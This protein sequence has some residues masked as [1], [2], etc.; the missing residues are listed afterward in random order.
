MINNDILSIVSGVK[1]IHCIKHIIF[2]CISKFL[3]DI[4]IY[5]SSKSLWRIWEEMQYKNQ[6]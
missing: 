3:E 4:L 1:C 5:C 2:I 6:E